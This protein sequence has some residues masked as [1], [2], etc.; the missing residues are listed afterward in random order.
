MANPPRQKPETVQHDFRNNGCQGAV[1]LK[2]RQGFFTSNKAT[3]IISGTKI[4]IQTTETGQE[5]RFKAPEWKFS[6][7]AEE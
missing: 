3:D 5:C 2:F 1:Q 4:P 7:L 6:V